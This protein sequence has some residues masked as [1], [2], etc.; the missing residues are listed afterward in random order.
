[1]FFLLLIWTGLI[2]A[3][4]TPELCPIPCP[5][6]QDLSGVLLENNW[7]TLADLSSM[8]E[9]DKRNTV[10]VETESMT[11]HTVS[12]LQR[13]ATAGGLGSVTAIA[14][15]A[16]LLIK[17]SIRSISDVKSMTYEPHL[18]NTLIVETSHRFSIQVRLLQRMNDHKLLQTFCSGICRKMFS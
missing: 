16:A 5:H 3:C 10:I 12:D 6:L 9:E 15:M 4:P 11:G 14:N 7:R 17:Y 2:S 13:R 1:M 8:S 18:R